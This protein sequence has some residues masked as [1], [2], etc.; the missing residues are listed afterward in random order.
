VPAPTRIVRALLAT[1]AVAALAIGGLTLPPA[2]A[3]AQP[4]PKNPKV[5]LRN[6]STAILSW[7]PAAKATSYE[8][9]VDTAPDFASPDFSAKTSNT[10]VVPDKSLVPGKNYWRVRAVAGKEQSK[11]VSGTFTVASVTTPIT[12]APVD[13]AVLAQPQNPPLLQW[14]SSQGAVSYKVEVDGDADLIGAYT[15]TT[16][17]TSLVVP[18]PLTTGDWYWRVTAVKGTG[19]VS[20]P[21]AISR[22]DISPLALPQITYPADSVNQ[23]IE[24]IVL[25][26]TPVPG[27]KTYDVQVALDDDFNNI[28][29]NVKNIQGSRYSPPVTLNS[30]QF[31][32]RVRAVDLAGQPTPWTESLY[33]FLRQWPDK[34]VAVYP[35]GSVGSP[36]VIATDKPYFQWTPVQHATSYELYTADDPA[37]T[38][39]V[40]RCKVVGTTYAPRHDG[41]CAFR[42][43]QVTYWEVRPIDAPYP[44]GDGLPGIFSTVQAFSW[45]DPGIT[46]TWDAANQATNLKVAVDGNG[47]ADPAKGCTDTLCDGVPTTP[48]FSWDPVPGAR[49]YR[50]YVAQDVNFTTSELPSV[51]ATNNTMLAIERG[52]NISALPES[53]AGSAYY[54]YVQPCKGPEGTPPCAQSPV[55]QNPPLPGAKSFR[56]ASPAINGLTSSDPSLDEITFSWGDYFD[57]NQATVWRGQPAN[58]SAK[59]YRI[60]VDNEPSFATPI[61]TKVVDQ[62]TYTAYDKLYPDGTYWWRVQAVDAANNGLTWSPVQTFTKSTPPVVPSSPVGGAMVSGTTPLRWAAQPF[63]ASYTVEVYKNNDLT[64]STANR[65]FAAT[66]KTAAVAPSTPIPAASAPYVWRVRRTDTDGNAGPWS[67]PATFYSTGVAPNLLQPKAGIWVKSTAGLFEWTEVPNAASYRVNVYGT[68]ASTVSTVAT[69]WAPSALGTGKY[70]WNVTAIDAGGNALA[71]SA[72]RAFK[73]DASLPVLTS[74]TGHVVN[75]GTKLDLRGKFSEKVKG[76]SNSSIKLYKQGSKKAIKA[77]VTLGKDKKSFRLVTKGSRHYKIGEKYDIVLSAKIRDYQGNHLVPDVVTGQIVAKRTLRVPGV[78]GGSLGGQ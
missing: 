1:G 21:S 48:V 8:V 30:D 10:K 43:G 62:T 11:W 52:D 53:Q 7:K 9:Q 68:K 36:S 76:V 40:D 25:D 49:S 57:I 65:V 55:S 59:N 3:A 75:K 20:L 31:W 74:L 45:T 33:G 78:A 16:K 38:L 66:V 70:T 15:Y 46:G 24:D 64:F 67:A 17:T 51:P 13:G 14:S 2:A 63:A 71:T 35:T 27:A 60:Q 56:K 6:A 73:V 50:V 29:L 47:I 61:D 54:W 58:Q 72:T 18:D 28:A 19:L 5:T 42:S 26:W 39:G 23:A 77:K 32:W 4:V 34:P 41:D 44:V 22:F 37:M 12:L 69:A